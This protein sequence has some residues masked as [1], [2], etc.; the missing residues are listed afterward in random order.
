MEFY[1]ADTNILNTSNIISNKSHSKAYHTSR[2]LDFTKQLNEIL[3]QEKHVEAKFS[4][5]FY[6]TFLYCLIYY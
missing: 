4:G 3:N 1:K 6:F 5:I 2:L